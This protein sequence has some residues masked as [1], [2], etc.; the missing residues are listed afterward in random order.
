[1]SYGEEGMNSS[2]ANV[3]MTFQTDAPIPD[4]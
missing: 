1:L 2:A 4:M 3:E